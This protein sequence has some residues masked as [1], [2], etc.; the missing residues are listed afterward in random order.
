MLAPPGSPLGQVQDT[1]V[2]R[3][4]PVELRCCPPRRALLGALNVLLFGKAG[5]GRRWRTY[6]SR[7]RL[8]RR[9]LGRLGERGYRQQGQGK[10]GEDGGGTH[11]CDLQLMSLVFYLITRAN[12]S[13][14]GQQ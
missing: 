12:A 10:K 9:L 5:G 8:S 1:V 2:V 7:A 4:H 6:G 3:I 13:S 14:G 11:L